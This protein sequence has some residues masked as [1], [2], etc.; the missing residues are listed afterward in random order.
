[1]VC[2]LVGDTH[3][4]VSWSPHHHAGLPWNSRHCRRPNYR[5]SS[6][7]AGLM[8]SHAA[9]AASSAVPTPDKRFRSLA[10]DRLPS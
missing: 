6:R 10:P 9:L 7:R 3:A 8:L 5:L 1:M 2:E 4:S